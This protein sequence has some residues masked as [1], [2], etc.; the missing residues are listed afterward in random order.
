MLLLLALLPVLLLLLLL[1]LLLSSARCALSLRGSKLCA[2]CARLSALWVK[3][4][5]HGSHESNDLVTLCLP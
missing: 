3:N 2:S 5:L 1:L 4:K